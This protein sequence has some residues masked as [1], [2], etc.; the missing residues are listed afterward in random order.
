LLS[1]FLWHLRLLAPLGILSPGLGQKQLGAHWPME[2]RR[3]GWIVGKIFGTHHHLAI[4]N[5]A[6][7][8]RVLGG[9]SD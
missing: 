9:D 2:R 3:A 6:Q 7:G 5:F 8:A 4:A 1:D